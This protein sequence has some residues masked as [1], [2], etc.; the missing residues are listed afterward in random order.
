MQHGLPTD[1]QQ[2]K[3]HF[4]NTLILKAP[5]TDERCSYIELIEY[6]E[7]TKLKG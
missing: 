7:I 2:K 3:R 5:L 4:C 1:R 6:V